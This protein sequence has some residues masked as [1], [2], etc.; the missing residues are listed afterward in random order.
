MKRSKQG[1][2]RGGGAGLAGR[3]GGVGALPYQGGQTPAGGKEP[4]CLRSQVH[5]PVFTSH[6]PWLMFESALPLGHTRETQPLRQKGAGRQRSSNHKGGGRSRT[7]EA[8]RVPA[9]L[10][11]AAANRSK[12]PDSV[13]ESLTCTQG[14]SGPGC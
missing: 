8:Q 6:E 14:G 3:D 10:V 9:H 5:L 1:A 2:P 13:R 4:S 11:P 7:P 12:L